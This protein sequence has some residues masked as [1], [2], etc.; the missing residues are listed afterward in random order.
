MADLTE[1]QFLSADPEV[2][3]LQ[4]QRALANLLT[5]QAFNQPQG[6]MISGHYVKPSALQSALPMINAAI[7]GLT[8]ANLDT[9]Q[10]ELAAALRQQKG[11]AISEFQRLMSDPSTR[12]QAMQYA[13]KNPHLQ[14]LA[15]ELMKPRDVAEGGR[16]VIPGIGSEGIEIAKGNEKYRAPLQID[17]GKSIEIRDPKDPTKVLQVLP[18]THV[19]APHAS[20]LVP[21]QGGFA[22]YNP[23]TKTFLPIGGGQGGAAGT[24]T[25]A[26][27]PPLPG[28][29]QTQASSINEQKSTINDVLKAVEGNR[30]YFGAKY[31][32][33]GIFAGELGTSKMNQKLPSDAVEARSQVFN[34]AS[35]VI[36][37]RAGTAQSKNESAIIMRFLPSEF[38]TDKVII[39][40]LN[41]FNKYLESKEK[42]ISPVV[43]AIQTYRPGAAQTS[44]VTTG[45]KTQ[46]F[47]PALL[48]FMTPEQQALFKQPGN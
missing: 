1:Q 11:E 4:R 22:E 2:L 46:N 43:G 5:G 16:V 7:G 13:A 12:G 32:A 27:M 25:G 48:Q 47:D 41:G 45:N 29:L 8:N 35:S 9:K 38:D 39:D 44:A 26:L 17:T 40:K 36:K 24:P 23:N 19:F 10:T 20:Q 21:V 14:G 30:Q 3:G 18:K 34:T 28:P 6:Q 33:P 15:Q 42:G 37:E 31:A